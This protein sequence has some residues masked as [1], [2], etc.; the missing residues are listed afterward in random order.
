[1]Q[2]PSDPEKVFDRTAN[3]ENTQI[4][5][6][7][8]DAAEKWCVLIGI[9]PGAAERSAPASASKC[10]WQRLIAVHVAHVCLFVLAF[11]AS[12]ASSEGAWRPQQKVRW[13]WDRSGHAVV[14]FTLSS[15]GSPCEKEELFLQARVGEGL[16]AAVL[17]R[18]EAQPSSGGARSC[19]L[20]H[21]G[22]LLLMRACCSGLSSASSNDFSPLLV[23][24]IVCQ[25]CRYISRQT[26]GFRQLTLSL[27][28]AQGAQE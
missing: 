6:Y 25:D 27:D 10:L 4:I 23:S 5:N 22:K 19:L 26:A 9:A 24:H 13:G 7:R 18:A 17:R 15:A 14:V 11:A 1:M 2:G 28:P 16:H 21:Q 12:L 8:V 3:L 20:H